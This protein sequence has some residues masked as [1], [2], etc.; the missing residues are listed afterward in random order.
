MKRTL[1]LLALALTLALTGQAAT[2]FPIIQRTYCGDPCSV[3]GAESPC[4][5]YPSGGVAY[6]TICVCING[7]WVG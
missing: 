6:R 5:C 4:T 3:Q 1:Q 2:A 7:T